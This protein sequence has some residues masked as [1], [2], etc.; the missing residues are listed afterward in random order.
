M[1]NGKSAGEKETCLRENDLFLCVGDQ[2]SDSA[3][4][5]QQVRVQTIL[6]YDRREVGPGVEE[7]DTDKLPICSKI[8][9][10]ALRVLTLRHG[11]GVAHVDI[12]R[13]RLAIIGDLQSLRHTGTQYAVTTQIASSVSS[14][15]TLSPR[16][17][18]YPQGKARRLP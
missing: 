6:P 5:I 2:L 14:Y 4:D 1:S 13:I 16:R 8:Q 3:E 11:L 17:P 18:A 7:F 15:T 10:D 12:E 9:D